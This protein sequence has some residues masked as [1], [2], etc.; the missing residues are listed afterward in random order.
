MCRFR[1]RKPLLLSP[2]L[3]S[4]GQYSSALTA[5][6][7]YGN[8][9]HKILTS[10][11]SILLS[12]YNQTERQYIAPIAKSY[13]LQQSDFIRAFLA[14]S[15]PFITLNKRGPKMP[16]AK[17]S[18]TSREHKCRRVQRLYW[19]NHLRVHPSQRGCPPPIGRPLLA[20]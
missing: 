20:R 13:D 11:G 9:S 17:P 18:I 2:I 14:Q 5:L 3:D 12:S 7:P 15:P 8:D 4:H 6:S 16:G 1:L 10:F 19:L